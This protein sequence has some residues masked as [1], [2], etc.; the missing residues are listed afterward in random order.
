[1]SKTRKILLIAVCIVAALIIAGAIIVPRLLQVDRYRPYIV[2]LIE[3]KT[4]WQVSIGRLGLTVL[5]TLTV[6]VDNFAI[7]NPSGFPSGDWLRVSRINARLD[8]GALWH[9][10]IVI[11]S[12]DL[13]SPDL[14]LISGAGGRWNY[15]IQSKRSAADAAKDG[16]PAGASRQA[17]PPNGL[18]SGQAADQPSFTV[19][20]IAVVSL[21]DGSLSL[22][23]LTPQGQA[24]PP[25]VVAQSISANLKDIDL[26]A[27]AAPR[28]ASA[29][30]PAATGELTVKNL[31]AGNLQME[32]AVSDVQ[33]TPAAV[34][35]KNLKFDFYNGHGQADIL[36]NLAA[37]ILSYTAQGNLTG[38]NAAALL[39]RFPQAR[40]QMTGNLGGHFTFSGDNRTSADPW[41]GKQGQGT[42]TVT[43]G[44][45]PKLQLDKAVLELARIAGMG[46]VS[47]DLAA[48]SSISLDWRLANDVITTTN[49]RVLGNGV[50]LNGSGTVGLTGADRLGFQ[51]AAEIAAKKNA[52]TN[53]LA[54]ASGTT[55]S[56]GKLGVPFTLTGT[57][58]QPQF[59]LNTRNALGS[60]LAAPGQK[61]NQ[62][63]QN[64]QNLFNLFKRKK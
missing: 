38:V 52:L 25:L 48:F 31:E 19:Q 61:P 62:T 55:F 10:Q 11:R 46:P 54:D 37:P 30:I 44:R 24:G 16:P 50:T 64:I 15:D 49:V 23:S 47:G 57:L 17:D 26:A 36:L 34:A 9:H 56:N 14:S 12:L 3:Q 27:F 13:S 40:G 63:Q 53:I 59:R 20:S 8:A 32:N 41:A 4:G 39:A 33:A 6:Q 5:P 2:S 58:D 18:P 1:M 45:L 51:G 28:S 21:K 35:L 42:L 22:A 29:G 60:A 7:A 43:K